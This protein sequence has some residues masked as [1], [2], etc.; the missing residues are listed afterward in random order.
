MLYIVCLHHCM[1]VCYMFIKY[2][3]INQSINYLYIVPKPPNKTGAH[4]STKAQIRSGLEI[5]MALL[6]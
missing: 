5:E 1:Y 4:Y 3:S 6:L 2:Q